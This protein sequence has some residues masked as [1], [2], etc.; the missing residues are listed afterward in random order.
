MV[1]L[2]LAGGWLL[3]LGEAAGAAQPARESATI[4]KHGEWIIEAES[5]GVGRIGEDPEASGKRFTFQ[6]QAFQPVALAAAPSTPGDYTVW[7]R[8]QHGSLVLKSS[9]RP[10]R[11]AMATIEDQ[12]E[13]AQ[14]LEA[15]ATWTWTR[16][17][18]F[19]RSELGACV[20][21]LRA[22]ANAAEV[23]CLAFTSKDQKPRQGLADQPA[24]ATGP[25]GITLIE[26]ES[27]GDG[28]T[29]DDA[30]ASGGKATIAQDPWGP[31]VLAALPKAGDEFTVW[32]RHRGGV[33][34]GKAQINAQ[35]QV[36]LGWIWGK[37]ATW[38]WSRLG[39]Y[40]RSRL[41]QGVFVL[42]HEQD[43]VALDCLAYTV[44]D[45]PP[46]LP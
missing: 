38:Q 9:P 21:L 41:G 22:A 7:V 16:L 1:V 36:D 37:P 12:Q 4:S 24:G 43:E 31:L 8:H 2:L 30:A 45:Q 34:G 46:T 10:G 35:T 18:R 40:P 20:I 26:A 39:R 15:P 13:L 6:D 28:R 32:L 29:I 42:R 33:I 17:G 3:G 25:A 27:R 23:D 5:C 44:T 14:S 19:P 11:Q